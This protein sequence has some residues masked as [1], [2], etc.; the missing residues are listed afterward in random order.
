[1][2]EDARS[3]IVNAAG[4]IFA[5]KGFQRSTVREICQ[6]AE[7]NVASVNYY[8][9]DKKNLYIE[10]VK[11]ANSLRASQAPMPAMSAETSPETR[12]RTFIDTLVKRMV[13]IDDSTW[14]ARL[15]MREMLQPTGAC[16]EIVESHLRPEFHLLLD[17]LR[18]LLP[19][20]V[21]EH[22]P[23]QVG[24]S[25]VGQCLFYRVAGDVV[26][27]IV[28]AEQFGEHYGVEQLTDHIYRM[29]I[30]ALTGALPDFTRSPISHV[31]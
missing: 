18:E 9:G 16:R 28:P 12:L 13:G 29:S 10:A 3:R 14:H 8:F 19:D 24:F 11:L 30:A 21:S 4:P 1:M 5:S 17:I 25:I 6:A 27:F 15:M 31:G 22:V 23:Y 20:N 26:R 7:V 2:S